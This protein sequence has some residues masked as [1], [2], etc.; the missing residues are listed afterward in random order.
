MRELF[1][2]IPLLLEC[3][4]MDVLVSDLVQYNRARDKTIVMAARGV[5]NLIRDI[6]PALLKR[7]QR[8]KFHN[9]AAKPHRFGE[10]V[11]SEGVDGAELLAE[12]EAAGRFDG[13][14]N[15]DGWE[16]ASSTSDEDGSE[17]EWVNMS[18][19]EEDTER[20]NDDGNSEANDGEAEEGATRKCRKLN[21]RIV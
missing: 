21:R 13:E 19:D 10:L 4:G 12:A 9:E 3:E 2:R 14:D 6:H 7:K 1:R 17:D 15:K 16:V 18:S 11:A 5:L 8:G 20:G